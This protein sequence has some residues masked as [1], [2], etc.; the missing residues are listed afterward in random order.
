MKINENLLNLLYETA[1][2]SFNNDEIP[3]SAVILN[4][5]DEIVCVCGNDRQICN[6]VLNHAEINAIIKAE[7]IL[8]DWRLD[9]YYMI[10]TL[11]PCDMCSA[12]IKEC[13]LDNVYYFLPRTG[14]DKYMVEICNKFEIEGYE[15]FKGKIKKLLTTFFD[16]KRR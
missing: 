16:K 11:E 2:S 8:K 10:C 5:E 14:T 7:S 4:S 13:R 15:E 9:G 12:V 6:S 3:V 1:E